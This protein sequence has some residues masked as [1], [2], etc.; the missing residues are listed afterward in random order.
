VIDSLV[1][2]KPRYSELNRR[3]KQQERREKR[4]ARQRSKGRQK[5]GFSASIHMVDGDK[6]FANLHLNCR[7]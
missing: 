1:M 2:P 6:R 4:E 5:Q 3:Q 7:Q